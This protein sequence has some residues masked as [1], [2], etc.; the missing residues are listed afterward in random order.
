MLKILISSCLSGN[1]VKYNG[2]N[3]YQKEL[4]ELLNNPNIK[5]YP[6]C[7]EVAGGLNIPRDPCEIINDKIISNK[8]KDCTINYQTGALKAL[9]I[10]KK[11]NIKIAILKETSPSCGNNEIYDGSFNHII[12]KGK[13]LTNKLLNDNGIITFSEKEID[14]IKEYLKRYL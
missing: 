8:G 3:N 6:F 9:K 11:E 2:G 4:M 1:N 12:I 7:P 5:L 13:G 14:Q 10:I